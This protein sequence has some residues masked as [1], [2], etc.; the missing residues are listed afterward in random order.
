MPLMLL[1]LHLLAL[2]VGSVIFIGMFLLHRRARAIQQSLRESAVVRPSLPKR[3]V[4]WLAVRASDRSGVQSALKAGSSQPVRRAGLR[5]WI[6]A[7]PV[8]GWTMVTGPGLPNPTEDVDE[9][10]RF[11][12]GLSRRLGHVQFFYAE[13]VG[14][15]HAWARLD[16]GCVTR[17]YAWAGETVWHQG[18]QTVAEIQLGLK[19]FPY[20]ASVGAREMSEAA[21]WNVEKI[22]LL[23]ARWSVDPVRAAALF[24][25]YDADEREAF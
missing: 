16:E 3:P 13:S 23:A 19:C 2:G 21:A 18:R 5:R 9:C 8:N 25:R 1:L 20:G 10:F 22:P 11:L 7:P 4:L 6:V 17:A 24:P 14:H 12:L 15:H